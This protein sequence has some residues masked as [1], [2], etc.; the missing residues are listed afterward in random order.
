MSD[1]H[2]SGKIWE[3]IG[4]PAKDFKIYNVVLNEKKDAEMGEKMESAGRVR[5]IVLTLAAMAKIN[6]K[7]SVARNSYHL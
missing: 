1:K 7:V 5:Q 2:T 4:N 3:N 6:A